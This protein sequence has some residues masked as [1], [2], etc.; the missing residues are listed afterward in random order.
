M[1][2]FRRHDSNII[3]STSNNPTGKAIG[4]G[5]F[6][7]SK[8]VIDPH[9]REAMFVWQ[10]EGA[11]AEKAW[12]EGV[13]FVEDTTATAQH[14]NV[15]GKCLVGICIAILVLPVLITHPWPRRRHSRLLLCYK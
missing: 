10:D 11:E 13:Q 6:S 9:E 4:V 8:P 3:S 5:P 7:D 12:T 15:A 1:T 2:H 14:A